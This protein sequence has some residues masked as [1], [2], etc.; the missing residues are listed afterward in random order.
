MAAGDGCPRDAPHT[1]PRDNLTMTRSLCSPRARCAAGLFLAAASA[2]WAPAARAQ[3]LSTV[4]Y[5]ASF[6]TGQTRDFIDNESWIGFNFDGQR[7]VNER[8]SLGLSFGYNE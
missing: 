3:Y 1:H 6:P 2:I 7:F 4:S 8:A 5:S